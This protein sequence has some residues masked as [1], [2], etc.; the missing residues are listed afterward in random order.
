M[1]KIIT[2]GAA[3]TIAFLMSLAIADD[4][5]AQ[6]YSGQVYVQSPSGSLY[7]SQG[8]P[9]YTYPT[10][11]SYPGTYYYPNYNYRYPTYY[12]PNIYQNYR[13]HYRNRSRN[14]YS[15]NPRRGVSFGYYR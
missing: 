14:R 6:I 12:R 2:L 13:P 8:Y 4:A 3:I 5:N 7:Y 11:V 10:V 15:N 9:T 1:K